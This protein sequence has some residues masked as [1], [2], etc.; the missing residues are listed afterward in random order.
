MP[1]IRRC[2]ELLYLLAANPELLPDPSDSAN[3][4]FHAVGGGIA[5]ESLGAAG[6]A[7]SFMGRLYLY[8][9]SPFVLSAF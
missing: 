7:S 3:A 8:L 4:Y 5:L 9:Q 6:L 2:L 1:R